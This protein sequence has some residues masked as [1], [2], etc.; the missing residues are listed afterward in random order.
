[1][2]AEDDPLY[3]N[4]VEAS[5]SIRKIAGDME[6]ETGTLGKLMKDDALYQDALLTLNEIRA[7]VD[8]LRETTPLATFTSIFFGAF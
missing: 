7:A 1:M 5:S 8:D 3:D 4:L 2:F 6:S